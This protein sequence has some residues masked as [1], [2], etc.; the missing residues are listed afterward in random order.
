MGSD[1]KV[2]RGD[3]T[4]IRAPR[5]L[6]PAPS[7]PMEPPAPEPITVDLPVIEE[8]ETA[9]P[10]VLAIAEELTTEDSSQPKKA[11]L[12]PSTK[13]TTRT[14]EIKI[15]MPAVPMPNLKP[16][17]EHRAYAAAKAQAAKVPRKKL[18]LSGILLAIALFTIS[19]NLLTDHNAKVAADKN[20]GQQSLTKGTPDY[21][22]V[23]PTGKTI[24]DLGGWTLVSPT[25]RDPVYA[26]IDKIGNMQINVSQQPLPKEFKPDTAEKIEK[27]AKEYGASEKLTVGN[28]IVHIGT[29]E[30]GPQSVIFY[31]DDLLILMK[32]SVRIDNGEWAT[33]VN[34]LR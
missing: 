33:Y 12:H 18:A 28:T 21:A 16:I 19:S 24:R 13:V 22:T 17:T 26:Y 11:K 3:M 32:S 8:P 4:D 14:V 15:S 7:Q 31:R 29:S 5:P 34:S 27:L 10:L 1:K 20:N 9:A 25:G 6:P 30:K 23:L 2:V